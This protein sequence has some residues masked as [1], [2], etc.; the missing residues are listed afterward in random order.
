VCNAASRWP[1]LQKSIPKEG[2]IGPGDGTHPSR[3]AL[4]ADRRLPVGEKGKRGGVRLGWKGSTDVAGLGGLAVRHRWI[5]RA[6]APCGEREAVIG[7]L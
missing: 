1:N 4:L 5:A 3:R 2:S 7:R 6:R